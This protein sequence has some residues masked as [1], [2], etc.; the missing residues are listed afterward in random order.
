MIRNKTKV[1]I[2][3]TLDEHKYFS[4]SD[5]EIIIKGKSI[6]LKYEFDE[7]FYFK[8]NLPS[9]PTSKTVK[10]SKPPGI[11]GTRNYNEEEEIETYVVTGKVSP[12]EMILEEDLRF[13][14]RNEISRQI[15][16]W[17]NSIWEELVASP[18]NKMIDEQNEI[19]EKIK[20]QVNQIPEDY[21]TKDEANELREKINSLE[22]NLKNQIESQ[23]SENDN[24][25]QKL[26]ELE[27]EMDSL[28]ATIPLLNKR[29]WF[30]SSMT[31]MYKWI[32]KENNRKLLK[33]GAKLLKPLL[34]ESI[35]DVLD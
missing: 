35:K 29:N 5:F 14:G 10:R 3:E 30:K 24:L 11:L 23:A 25:K 34:P 28:R 18:L 4:S 16:R 27:N 33:D 20:S 22:E 15:K 7:R 21:F 17:L 1:E 19:I 8:I 31:K 12:G 32:S 6:T 26:S 13:E 9:R 2:N